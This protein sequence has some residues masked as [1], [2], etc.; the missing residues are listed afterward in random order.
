[1]ETHTGVLVP[2][3]CKLLSEIRD[4]GTRR[5]ETINVM[6]VS[7]N[8]TYLPLKCGIITSHL[9]HLTAFI[10]TLIF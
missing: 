4:L 2:S 5:Q 1:M 10:L 7:S 6:S 9:L 3:Y 8:P